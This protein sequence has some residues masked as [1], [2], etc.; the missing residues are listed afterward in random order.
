MILASDEAEFE[1]EYSRLISGLEDRGIDRLNAFKN[2]Q[3]K[4]NC[5]EYGRK[6]ES[7]NPD[8]E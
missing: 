5:E 2:E 8:E 4:K 1:A 6:I 3:Y 7:V